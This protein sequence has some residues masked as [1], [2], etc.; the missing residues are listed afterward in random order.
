VKFEGGREGK[1]ER[2]LFGKEGARGEAAAIPDF[3][4]WL[5]GDKF[6]ITI[7]ARMYPCFQPRYSSNR[8]KQEQEQMSFFP[9]SS[10]SFG[11]LLR[12]WKTALARVPVS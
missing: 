12:T 10:S 2:W 9:P 1:R 8:P 11:H 5:T 3:A 7:F 4:L 6:D